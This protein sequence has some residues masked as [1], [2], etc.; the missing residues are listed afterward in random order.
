MD[1]CTDVRLVQRC[2]GCVVRGCKYGDV[3]HEKKSSML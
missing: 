2:D 3:L 1:A